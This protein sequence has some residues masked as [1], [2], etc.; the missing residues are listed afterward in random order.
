MLPDDII[1]KISEILCIY[2]Y[3]N[4]NK[5]YT[6][7]K[8]FHNFISKYINKLNNSQETFYMATQ[9][10]H[11]RPELDQIEYLHNNFMIFDDYISYLYWKNNSKTYTNCMNGLD[12]S[13]LLCDLYKFTTLNTTF[14]TFNNNTFLEETY[15][16]E[17]TTFISPSYIEENK[18]NICKLEFN[19][20][21]IY[22]FTE[23]F[24]HCYGI[25]FIILPYFDERLLEISMY[26]S[27]NIVKKNTLANHNIT[28][29]NNIAF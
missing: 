25:S 19:T 2:D 20:Y 8:S 7:N 6:I 1:E 29:I 11:W 27:Y 13:V 26:H 14:S 21:F 16:I 3:S 5:Y 23:D 12:N 28:K 17:D 24:N 9:I 4:I 18:N 15:E 22:Y 10:K